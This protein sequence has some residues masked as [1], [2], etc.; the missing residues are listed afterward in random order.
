VQL[1]S[2]GPRWKVSQYFAAGVT[3]IG[4]ENTKAACFEQFLLARRRRTEEYLTKTIIDVTRNVAQKHKAGLPPEAMK[5]LAQPLYDIGQ[6][7]G[8][9]DGENAENWLKSIFGPLPDASP[10]LKTSK[11]G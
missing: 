2:R 11:P 4:P 5:N 1:S 9:I 10:V 7:G 3:A 8:S 6:S